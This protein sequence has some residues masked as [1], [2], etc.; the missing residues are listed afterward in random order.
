M[1]RENVE[2]VRRVYESFQSGDLEGALAHFHPEVTVDVTD[3]RPD[4]EVGHG[5][6]DLVRIIV[7]EWIGAFD[8][9]HEEVE[10]ISDYGEQVYVVATQRGRGKETGLAVEARYAVVYR[11]EG[12]KISSM[13]LYA[14]PAEALEA[15]GLSE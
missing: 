14:D 13:V 5:H 1:S 4:S 2:I 3:G 8:D 15:V 11:V 9:W 7:G 6:E 10:A 12:R